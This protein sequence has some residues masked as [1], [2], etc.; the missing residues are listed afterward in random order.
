MLIAWI[1]MMRAVPIVS[2][3][4]LCMP[5]VYAPL[6]VLCLTSVVVSI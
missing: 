5:E 1:I 2:C 6:E 4:K 3:C